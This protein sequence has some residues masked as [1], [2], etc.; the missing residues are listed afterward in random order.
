MTLR[1][2]FLM[3]LW[4]IGMVMTIAFPGSARSAKVAYE[5]NLRSSPSVESQW[6]DGLPESGNH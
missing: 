6:I 5:V 4:G 1:Q 3:G 2:Q